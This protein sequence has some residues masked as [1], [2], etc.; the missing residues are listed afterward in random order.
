MSSKLKMSASALAILGAWGLLAP[1]ALA[2][3]A[4]AA[5]ETAVEEVVVTGSSIRGVA[6]VG[7]NLVSVGQQEIE[8][9]AAINATQLVQTVPAIT[10]TGSAP[11]GE[12]AFGYY[13]PTIHSLGGSSSNT[14]LVMFDGMRMVGG[15][16][17]YAQV[18]PNIIPTTA[19]QRVEVLA[20][21]ASSIYGSDAVAGVINFIGRSRFN[22]V[23][24]N[25]RVGF[26][27]S[28]RQHDIGIIAGTTW[29]RG[30]VFVAATHAKQ[31]AVDAADRPL[32]S[33]G[34]YRF[35]GG[36]NTNSFNCSPATIRTPRSGNAIYLSPSATTTV[37]QTADNAPCNNSIYGT[38]IPGTQRDNLMMRA[39]VDVTERLTVSGTMIWNHL[40]G[41]RNGTP[42]TLANVTVFGPGS[43]RGDQI[44]PFFVAP[45]GD[46]T[47]T[48]ETINWLNLLTPNNGIL[49]NGNE[50]SQFYGVAEYNLGNDWTATWSTGYGRSRSW[51]DTEDGFCQPCALLALNGTATTSGS[52][53]Q[54]NI[55]GQNVIA[56]QS[57]TTANALDVWNPPGS[58]RTSPEVLRRIVGSDNRNIHYNKQFQT[59]LEFQGPLFELPAG[60]LRMATGGEFL[61]QMQDAKTIGN[62]PVGPTVDS[63]SYVLF[64]LKRHVWSGYAEFAV[65]V[66][67]PEMG[68]PLVQSFDLS[69]SGRID[70]YSDVGSTTNPKVAFN[71]RPINFV[72]V[73]GN[74]ATSFVAPPQFAIGDPNL[75]YQRVAAGAGISGRITVP[76]QFFPE[77]RQVPGADCSR[78]TS[79]DIGLP[80]NQG[81]SR[82]FGSGLRGAKPQDGETWSIGTDID[83]SD[84]VP[85]NLQTSFT[86]WNNKLRGGQG[87]LNFSQIVNTPSLKD[88]LVICPSACTPQQ[89][90]EFTRVAY[91]A[92]LNV[93]L[94]D[95][96]YFLTDTDQGNFLNMDVSGLD[97]NINYR[98][99]TDTMGTFRASVSGT[100]YTKFDQFIGEGGGVYSTL[101]SSGFNTTFPSLSFR[102]R[103]GLGWDL[104]GFSADLWA[105]WTPRYR[106]YSA[107][108]V[109]PVQT[110]GFGPSGGG[111][112]V[113]ADL[114]FDGTIS[115]EFQDG[116]LEGSS[117]YVNATNILDTDPPFYSGSAG[118]ITTG[119]GGFNA[120]V[121][122]P[123]GRV[124]S[125]GFR[126]RF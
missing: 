56:R 103:M 77:V 4:Q 107:D 96:V 105:N 87:A 76:V 38:A 6:A 8:A 100:W 82:T 123:I 34:D 31:A 110:N 102:S 81:L 14:T 16:T 45:A 17:Q 93:A 50:T 26:G 53:T 97:F 124:V 64:N 122:N 33:A 113:K 115:Y 108:S 90:A 39:S 65:P 106:N 1:S 25:A 18:D 116:V 72:K 58:N 44:N 66:V 59:K 85:G 118:G 119:G 68:I 74:W 61:Q 111:D 36:R 10:N 15:G 62:G 27:D 21:G 13:T 48:Q 114:T 43:G 9:V 29:D 46:P 88:H 11:Q 5:P 95:Q 125:I 84:F 12:N 70:K 86:Y 92:R 30:S 51:S 83:F 7:S 57:L 117:V 126:G 79:C 75:G 55:G 71:W 120:M 32:I 49:K 19:I 69:L 3:A 80:A 78:V 20:D 22:G 52:T 89:I 63:A 94:P 41:E 23:E 54:T 24:M 121:S 42:G 35:K 67:S 109:L 101:G 73:R 40:Y 28:Y 104:G 37:A 112:P 2:A 99:P 98:I 47:A 60:Q 91:G